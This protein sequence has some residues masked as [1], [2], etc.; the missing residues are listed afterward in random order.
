[1][2]KRFFTNFSCLINITPS[3]ENSR[4]LAINQFDYNELAKEVIMVL[5]SSTLIK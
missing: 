4:R 5:E 2:N 1:M 3:K